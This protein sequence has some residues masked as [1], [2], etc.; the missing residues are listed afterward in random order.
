MRAHRR[1]RNA[2]ALLAAALV[3]AGG[4]TGC[5][6]VP[7]ASAPQVVKTVNVGQPPAD[8]G[9]VPEP[10]AD[11]RTIVSGFL[12]NNASDDP[13]HTGARA[14]LT[15]A[16]KNR[17]SDAPQT[18]VVDSPQIGLFAHGTVSVIGHV[19]GTIDQNGN[20]SPSLQGTGG[21]A[22]GAPFTISVGLKKVAGQWRIDSVPN[23]LVISAAQFAQY[24]QQRV[25]YFYDVTEEH[26][27]PEPR[28]T[29]QTDPAS[30]ASWLLA[31]L[32][33]QPGTSLS[34]ALPSIPNANQVHVDVTASTLR[35]EI[36]GASQLDPTT[37]DRMAAQ[38]ALTLDQASPGTDLEVTDGG[39]PVPIQKVGGPVFAAAEFSSLLSPA[40]S[41]PSLYY[42]RDGGVVDD[43]GNALAGPI[44]DGT[45]GLTSVALATTITSSRLL[46]AGVS[47]FGNSARLLMGQSS[48][49]LRPTAVHGPLSRPSW[50]PNADEVWIGDGQRVYRVSAT[51]E[52]Q[53]VQLGSPSGSVTGTIRALRFSPEGSRVALVVGAEDGTSQVWIGTV[54]RTASAV[55]V[56]GLVAISP[57]GIAVTDVAWN[58]E[59]KLFAIGH[60]IR[61][62]DAGVFELQCDGS[63]WTDR[64]IGNLPQ[65]P[66]SITVA[67][68]VVAAVSVGNTV[69]VQRAGSWISPKGGTTVGTNP[70]YQE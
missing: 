59:L 18:T 60:D 32:I 46:V 8:A 64:G 42:I 69:W 33:T 66:D 23:G 40:N 27:V 62:L 30:L 12:T 49:A 4:V 22:G 70:V 37:R 68:N 56:A 26:I 5:S 14:F 51:G 13:H 2:V 17:W 20:Y 3:V 65:A 57:S 36:P 48:G 35:V 38:L 31:Q 58:D 52:A 47:G 24:Y 41:A 43:N 34:T 21:G 67:E 19:V 10:G 54:V 16:E 61:T 25:V 28:Y 50:M 9:V 7:T 15:P 63:L 6:G 45:Y 53:A 1:S 55:R 11:P 39:T 44:G 29:T